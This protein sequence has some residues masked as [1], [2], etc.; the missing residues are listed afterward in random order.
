MNYDNPES[1]EKG[2]K[3]SKDHAPLHIEKLKKETMLHI[4]K[5]VYKWTMHNPNARAAPNYSTFEDLAQRPMQCMLWRCS[6]VSPCN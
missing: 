2:K 4:P 3:A 1:T 5:G 6:K